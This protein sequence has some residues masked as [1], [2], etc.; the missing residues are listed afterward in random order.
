MRCEAGIR[1][2]SEPITIALRTSALE[3]ASQPH[4]IASFF[5]QRGLRSSLGT[6]LGFWQHRIKCIHRKCSFCP[7]APCCT[8]SHQW[9]CQNKRQSRLKPA[10]PAFSAHRSMLHSA[11]P[12]AIKLLG[13]RLHSA[14]RSPV[15]ART[16]SSCSRPQPDS[17]HMLVPVSSG[18]LRWSTCRTQAQSSPSVYI[19]LEASQTD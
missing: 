5:L 1:P 14:M 6:W 15:A 10:T 4:R 7:R 11:R 19:T 16:C 9:P 13:A 8:G 2:S 18:P 3:S 17:K 12:A